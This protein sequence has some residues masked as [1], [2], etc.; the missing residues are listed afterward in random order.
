MEL[1]IYT[2]LKCIFPDTKLREKINKAE[3]DIY[4]PSLQ[5]GIEYDGVYWHKN[6]HEKD[7]S[8]KLTLEGKG[9]QLIRVREIGL[10]KITENDIIYDYTKKKEK[11]L[12]DSLLKK[13]ENLSSLCSSDQLRADAYLKETGLVNNQEFIN[14]LDMLPSPLPGSSLADQNV[15]LAKEWHPSKN[16]RLTPDN[17][18]PASNK[19][20]WWQCKKGHEWES[21]VGN[22]SKSQGCPYC[23]GR[24]AFGDNCLAKVNPH[25]AKEWHP[26]KNGKLAPENVTPKSNKKAWWQCDKG[27]EWE[28]VVSS[29]SKSG[30]PYCAGNRV[31]KETSLAAKKPQLANEWHPAKNGKLTP[32][33]V[34]PGS[35]QK[36]WWQCDKGHEW[37]AVICSRSN[38]SGCPYCSG[39]R[40]FE[41]NCLAT[42]NP[43][44]AKEWHPTENG[45]LT[46]KDV[47]PMSHERVWWQ[48][49]KGHAWQARIADR[50]KRA[51]CPYC[52]RR[53]SDSKQLAL[54]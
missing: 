27:H 6:K 12:V 32:E 18:T 5:V 14:L 8:K 7:R 20:V 43:R 38:G 39:R 24:I 9:V 15:E 19:K 11:Q 33:D 30:C 21:L 3:C 34:T 17:V 13:I 26:S 31:T 29:R 52:A 16:G 37:E 49:D 1:R 23:S 2:E 40:V 4:I 25:V 44:L 10:D 35:N 50:S 53:K 36:A 47:M 42:V 28:A 22:R 41:D 46:P 48:C 45:E 51:G 54:L